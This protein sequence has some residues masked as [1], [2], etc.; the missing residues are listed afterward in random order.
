MIALLR[1]AADPG[2][3]EGRRWAEM[4]T[5][6]ILTDKLAEFGAS[7]KVNAEAPFLRLLKAEGREA[8][9]AFLSAH[10]DD[11]GRRSTADLD[12]LLEE[13]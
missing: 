3:G 10:G 9:D 2:A 12:V 13:C 6:R 4:R 7:S 8:A 1:Q 11:L 5:H